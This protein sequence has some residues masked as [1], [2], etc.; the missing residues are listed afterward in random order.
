MG[1]NS[2]LAERVDR[3]MEQTAGQAEADARIL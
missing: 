2:S 3:R 1:E